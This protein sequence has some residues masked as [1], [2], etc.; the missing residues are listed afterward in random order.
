MDAH[1]NHTGIV[2]DLFER[3]PTGYVAVIQRRSNGNQLVVSQ[4]THLTTLLKS[5]AFL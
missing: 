5:P 4:L 2:W 1:S 3:F